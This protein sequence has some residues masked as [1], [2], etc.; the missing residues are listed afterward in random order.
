MRKLYVLFLLL[1][2]G[3]TA[4]Y[5]PDPTWVAELEKT[6]YKKDAIWLGGD[7]LKMENYGIQLKSDIQNRVSMNKGKTGS[8]VGYIFKAQKGVIEVIPKFAGEDAQA[9][10]GTYSPINCFRKRSPPFYSSVTCHVKNW[11]QLNAASNGQLLQSVNNKWDSSE[12]WHHVL[13]QGQISSLALT[14]FSWKQFQ[15]GSGGDFGLGGPVSTYTKGY[16][17][18]TIHLKN[19]RALTFRSKA[20]PS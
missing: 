17:Y 14:T 6:G 10:A 20:I 7:A 16:R 15:G 18:P 19:C 4:G 9:C 11:Q 8:F 1:V 12:N 5:G 2:A 3:C 13:I